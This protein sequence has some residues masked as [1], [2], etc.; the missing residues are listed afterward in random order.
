MTNRQVLV[1]LWAW[2]FFGE[3]VEAKGIVGIELYSVSELHPSSVVNSS[4]CLLISLLSLSLNW[5]P[6]GAQT[7]NSPSSEIEADTS[8]HTLFY[9]QD[10][11]L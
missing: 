1:L 8:S 5:S 6:T 11:V 7:T 10:R 2:G 4:N 9:V 3:R